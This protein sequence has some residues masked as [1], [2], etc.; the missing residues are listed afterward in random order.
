MIRVILFLLVMSSGAWAVEPGEILSNITQELRAR[1][2]SKELRCLVCRNENIDSSNAGIAKDLRLLVRERIIAGDDNKEVINF[3]TDRYGEYVLLNPKVSLNNL[4]LWI[5][6]P[7]F[8]LLGA[9]LSLWFIRSKK[10]IQLKAL[11]EEEITRLSN[12]MDD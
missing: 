6:G 11:T 12:L 7:L 4:I 10:N 2:I 3:I 8:L 9:L 1:E 5:S